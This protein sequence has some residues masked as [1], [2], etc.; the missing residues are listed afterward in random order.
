MLYSKTYLKRTKKR[1][2]AKVVKEHYLRDDIWCYVENC[3][4][5]KN[6]ES[7]LNAG[8]CRTK[9]LGIPHYI[10]PDTK[11]FM[12]QVFFFFLMKRIFYEK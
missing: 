2:A 11:V 10:V 7:V 12:N 8:A 5:C 9:L 3:A 4:L 1:N 6:T